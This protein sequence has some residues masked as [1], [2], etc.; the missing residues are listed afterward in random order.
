MATN[1]SPRFWKRLEEETGTP[2]EGLMLFKKEIRSE[3]WK[4]AITEE[5]FWTRLCTRFPVIQKEQ[6]K[7]L[8]LSNIQ[9]LP[10]LE[11]ISV[12]HEYADIH[13]LSN[14]RAEWIEPILADGRRF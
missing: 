10:A 13:L 2:Y 14:H 5:A 3:L 9:P 11:D 1:F 6:A 12:W 8:L 4:G 7:R